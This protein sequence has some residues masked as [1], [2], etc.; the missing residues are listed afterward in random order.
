MYIV[1]D[2]KLF[3]LTTCSVLFIHT[4]N[5]RYL[6]LDYGTVSFEKSLNSDVWTQQSA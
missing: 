1:F 3:D 4:W 5:T 6:K 2:W